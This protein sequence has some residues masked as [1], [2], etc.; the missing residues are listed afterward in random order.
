MKWF[1]KMSDCLC[2]PPRH[3]HRNLLD[4]HIIR[5]V[6]GDALFI[7]SSVATRI[8]FVIFQENPSSPTH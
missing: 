5:D 2:D 4:T 1:I 6:T 3:R 8:I 7:L